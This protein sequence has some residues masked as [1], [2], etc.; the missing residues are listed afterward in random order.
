[1]DCPYVIP[2]EAEALARGD[3]PDIPGNVLWVEEIRFGRLGNRF[4]GLTNILQLGFCCKSKLVSL[5][6]KSEVLAPGFFN[7][8][9]PGPRWFDFSS[10]PD[11]EGFD[12]NTCPAE[13][14]WAG[15]DALYL[16]GLDDE[17]HPNYTPG[18]RECILSGQRLVGCEA[19]HYFPM[20]MDLCGSNQTRQADEIADTGGPAT[21]SSLP[22]ITRTGRQVPGSITTPRARAVSVELE[23]TGARPPPPFQWYLRVLE[24]R[25]WDRVDV[26]T[27]GFTDSTHRIN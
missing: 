22:R 16:R 23:A 25:Q 15:G 21:S 1:P 2:T 18:L 19:A 3:D 7:E 9:I 26:V 27:N 4:L 17:E 11:T 8:G 5:P 13:I 12:P 14:T 20:D 6:P 10:A 24:D